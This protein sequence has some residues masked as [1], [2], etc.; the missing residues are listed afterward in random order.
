MDHL[1][2]AGAQRRTRTALATLPPEEYPYLSG[3]I[4]T[5]VSGVSGADAFNHGL[6]PSRRQAPHPDTG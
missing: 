5:I 2:P 3:H 6:A 4:N 1:D